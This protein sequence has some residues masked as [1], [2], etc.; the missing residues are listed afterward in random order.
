MEDPLFSKVLRNVFV[1]RAPA[2]L[3]SSVVVVFC[4]TRI[5]VGFA[6]TEMSSLIAVGMIYPKE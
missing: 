5:T 1:R 2:L 3:R 6:V 4:R